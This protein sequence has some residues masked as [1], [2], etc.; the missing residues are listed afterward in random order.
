MLFCSAPGISVLG[1][2][3]FGGVRLGSPLLKDIN[4]LRHLGI[5]HQY[6]DH[7]KAIS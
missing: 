6:Q 4:E 3:S 5:G 7:Q 2:F 1:A